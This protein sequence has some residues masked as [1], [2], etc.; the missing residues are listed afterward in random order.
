MIKGSIVA[1]ALVAGCASLNLWAQE[2][3]GEVLEQAARTKHQAKQI[4][5]AKVKGG[6]IKC[7][8]LKN[9]NGALIWSVAIV[10]V[11]LPVAVAKYRRG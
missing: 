10:A 11:S 1:V 4:A 5:L 6:K 8:E 2:N 7:V 9:V 3:E